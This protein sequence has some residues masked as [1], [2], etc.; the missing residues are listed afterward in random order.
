MKHKHSKGINVTHIKTIKRKAKVE[1]VLEMIQ[2]SM[3]WLMVLA[4][5]FITGVASTLIF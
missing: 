5:G 3:Y 1:M 2:E 4:A